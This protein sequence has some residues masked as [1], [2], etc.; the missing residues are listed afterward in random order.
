[1]APALG[2]STSDA[3]EKTGCLLMGCSKEEGL[4]LYSFRECKIDIPSLLK[5]GGG[6]ELFLE[7]C[8]VVLLSRCGV[9]RAVTSN[10]KLVRAA[11]VFVCVCLCETKGKNGQPAPR[12][13]R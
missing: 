2:N 3:L 5:V 9:A 8:V 13:A 11:R 6:I 10:T 12:Y 1:M 7:S 4:H